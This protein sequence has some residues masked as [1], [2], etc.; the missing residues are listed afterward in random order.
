MGRSLF[1]D[2]AFVVPVQVSSSLAL[3]IFAHESLA[4]CTLWFRVLP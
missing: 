2:Q 4:S 1:S 3:K